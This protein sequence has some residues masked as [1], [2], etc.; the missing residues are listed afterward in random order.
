MKTIYT[1]YQLNEKV[2]KLG[3]PYIGM[4][5]RTLDM[6]ARQWKSKLKLSYFPELIPLHT[7]TDGQRCFNWE[8]NKRVELGWPREK[9]YRGQKSMRLK[10]HES[11][12]TKIA[13]KENMKLATAASLK[14]EVRKQA[15]RK[16]G[17]NNVESGQLQSISSLGGKK[18]L[19]LK[20]GIHAFSKEQ[21]VNTSSKGGKIGGIIA[22]QS[23]NN[24]N[25]QKRKCIYCGFETTPGNIG[26]HHNENCR[27]K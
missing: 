14:S 25:K 23:K 16:V 9:S 1:V 8:Q 12:K 10:A 26:R 17:K 7:E 27:F 21:R 13:V 24:M 4:T 2:N 18:C 11:N 15:N 3:N 5:E 19:E 6:R 22:M 20:K